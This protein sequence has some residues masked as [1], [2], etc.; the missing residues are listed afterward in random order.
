MKYL[1]RHISHPIGDVF[2]EVLRFGG[3]QGEHPKAVLQICSGL[4]GLVFQPES[5]LALPH[6]VMEE[7]IVH[8]PALRG[9]FEKFHA[10][11]GY[12]ADPENYPAKLLKYVTRDDIER[13]IWKKIQRGNRIEEFYFDFTPPVLAYPDL[14]VREDRRKTAIVSDYYY[15]GIRHTRTKRIEWSPSWTFSQ[16]ASWNKGYFLQDTVAKVL[17]P[18]LDK[19]LWR[20]VEIDGN[21]VLL[22]SNE[23][24]EDADR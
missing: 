4:N 3:V 22:E 17:L 21:S 1:Y 11:Q 23:L 7:L 16:S 19:N 13:V 20:I 9:S 12:L 18:H 14:M 8:E 10:V 24:L 6:R 5:T 2:T 15:R